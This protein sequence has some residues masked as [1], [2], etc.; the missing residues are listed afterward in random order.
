MAFL[1]GVHQS[2]PFLIGCMAP[3]TSLLCIDWGNYE[4][5]F[6]SPMT[7]RH[8]ASSASVRNQTTGVLERVL[9]VDLLALT[10]IC[11]T[12][13]SASAPWCPTAGSSPRSQRRARSLH[14]PRGSFCSSAAALRCI[15]RCQCKQSDDGSRL[16][17]TATGA[18][19]PWH[20]TAGSS[21]RSQRKTLVI[22]PKV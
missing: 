11:S 8:R 21:P 6:C 20:P 10:L 4:T 17:S 18:S 13:T 15:F 3:R 16:C 1:M 7:V 12:A 14:L 5:W 22:K 2:F 19:T 9:R